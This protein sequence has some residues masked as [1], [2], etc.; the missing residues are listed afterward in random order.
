[1]H[2]PIVSRIKILSRLDI[3][4]KRLPQDGTFMVKI[5]DRTIDL[6]ISVMPTI[7]GEKVVLRILDRTGVVLDIGAK[8]VLRRMI[9]RN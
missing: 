1:M 4:E 3:S 6:R 5:H 2:L 9:L 8:W 7:Y